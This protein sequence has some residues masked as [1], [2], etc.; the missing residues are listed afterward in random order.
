MMTYNFSVAD[1]HTRIVDSGASDHMTCDLDKLFNVTP[2]TSELIIKLPT[3]DTTKITHIGDVR[4]ANG[5]LLHK[6]LYVPQFKHNLLSIHR[7]D[8]N[9]KC[10][11]NFKSDSCEVVDSTIGI[12]KV[13]GQLSNGLYYLKDTLYFPSKSPVSVNLSSSTTNLYALW[14]HRSGHAP[15][16]GLKHIPS[17]KDVIQPT[18][19]ICITC[20]LSKFTKLPY[21]LN[22]SHAKAIFE[23]I[24]IDTWGPYRV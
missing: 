19:E 4:M 9:N 6:V 3:G 2:A 22:T 10:V 16:S 13:V 1:K 8:A 5:L 18:K 14:H 23:L 7:L 20:P 12:V 17:L 15:L 24:H 21:E 11:V